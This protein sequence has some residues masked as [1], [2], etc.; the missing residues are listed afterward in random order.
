MSNEAF[1]EL[2]VTITTS[3]GINTD[4]LATGI[5]KRATKR[6]AICNCFE[7]S[8]NGS[9]ITIGYKPIVNICK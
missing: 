5:E 1:A 6:R 8:A 9:G 2:A 3:P 7:K 4:W